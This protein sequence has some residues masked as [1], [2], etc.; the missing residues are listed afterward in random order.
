MHKKSEQFESIDDV[1]TR[2]RSYLNFLRLICATLVIVSHAYPLGGFG[3]DPLIPTLKPS[4]SLGG[5]KCWYFFRI[6]RVFDYGFS[7][8]ARPFSVHRKQNAADLSC[9]FDSAFHGLAAIT[10][11]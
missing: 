6:V 3:T 2:S 8:S 5:V 7:D 4:T 10:F 11:L 1:M 9:V